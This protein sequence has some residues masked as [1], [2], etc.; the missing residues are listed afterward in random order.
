MALICTMPCSKYLKW[1]MWSSPSSP[2]VV[3]VINP[4]LRTRKPRF[5]AWRVWQH[6]EP[7]LIWTCALRSRALKVEL[8]WGRVEG[9][10]AP[11]GSCRP[12]TWNWLFRARL[13]REGQRRT[14]WIL[15]LLHPARA[16]RRSVKKLSL[17]PPCVRRV[18]GA[19]AAMTVFRLRA[20]S[21]HSPFDCHIILSVY[22]ELSQIPFWEQR[23]Q[24]LNLNQSVLLFET[25]LRR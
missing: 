11:T 23:W 6:G 24:N 4:T 19:S 10:G 1:V 14:L 2:E 13:K 16:P 7:G 12:L 22:C 20:H 18:L 21:L 8:P 5:T 9:D 3:A 15:S 17:H 25:R